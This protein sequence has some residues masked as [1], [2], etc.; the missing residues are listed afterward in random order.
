VNVRIIDDLIQ[1]QI[2]ISGDLQQ[3]L[4]NWKPESMLALHTIYEDLIKVALPS[5]ELDRTNL[6]ALI[7]EVMKDGQFQQRRA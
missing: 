6:L 2:S 1:E 4:L 5:E 3:V 7:D